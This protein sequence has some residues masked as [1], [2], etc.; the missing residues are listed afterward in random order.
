MQLALRELQA[1]LQKLYGVNVPVIR[2]YGSQARGNASP[3]SDIDIL[4]LYRR[5]VNP[6]KEIQRTAPILA[7]LNLRYGVLIS[8]LPATDGEYQESTEMFW[9]N[10]R[11]EGVPIEAI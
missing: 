7:D 11:R 6:G 5:A 10:V 2:V 9:R 4:L 8:V 3:D 1:E